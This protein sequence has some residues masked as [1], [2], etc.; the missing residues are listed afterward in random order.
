MNKAWIFLIGVIAVIGIA[1][2]VYQ[3]FQIR[4][5]NQEGNCNLA[6]TL[7]SLAR[8]TDFFD[9]PQVDEVWIEHGN[10]LSKRINENRFWLFPDVTMEE[11]GLATIVKDTPTVDISIEDYYSSH[12]FFSN[13]IGF[14][15]DMVNMWDTSWKAKEGTKAI[16][17]RDV[18]ENNCKDS[19]FLRL[20]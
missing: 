11:V 16:I 7:V 14:W 2:I 9:S 19:N 3:Q 20:R 17:V 13:G 1:V 15:S 12:N 5:L 8:T 6:L 18:I 10:Q 4:I